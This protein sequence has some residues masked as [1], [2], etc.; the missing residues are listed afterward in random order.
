MFLVRLT[1]AVVDASMPPANDAPR[2]ST[3]TS[4]CG[5]LV[6]S[7]AIAMSSCACASAVSLPLPVRASETLG[8]VHSALALALAW[9]LAWQSALAPQLSSAEPSHFGGVPAVTSHLPLH[10]NF[11]PAVASQ[12][13][14]QEPSHLPLHSTS[15]LP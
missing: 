12:E 2:A 1:P 4:S 9:Q 5:R 15:A 11:A 8:G 3:T 10:S 6:S 14:L 7:D 13:P